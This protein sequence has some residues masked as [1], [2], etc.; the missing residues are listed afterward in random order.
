M[1]P[2]AGP[3]GWFRS[4]AH[5]LGDA[6]ARENEQYPAF[7]PNLLLFAPGSSKVAVVFF[8]LFVSF[9]SRICPNW[10]CTPLFLV[11]DGFFV[12]R[13]SRRGVSGCKH[14]GTAAKGPRSQASSICI[15][16]MG[17]W[18][19]SPRLILSKRGHWVVTA[20]R[21]MAGRRNIPSTRGPSFPKAVPVLWACCHAESGYERR[22]KG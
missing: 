9:G 10:A 12:F 17:W 6:V 16:K 5:P 13:C 19:S 3:E 11:P 4:F 20:S 18:H 15:Y 22:R 2:G 7:T 14:G 21:M 1:C 8:S